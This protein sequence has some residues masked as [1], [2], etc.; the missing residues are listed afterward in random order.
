MRYRCFRYCFRARRR[1]R[2]TPSSPL[3]GRRFISG[4]D[5]MMMRVMA[6]AIAWATSH[7]AARRA[8]HARPPYGGR[9][10]TTGSARHIFLILLMLDVSRH[11]SPRHRSAYTFD[12]AMPCHSLPAVVQ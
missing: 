5:A 3:A 10:A 2:A 8:C 4:D 9:A 6:E 1:V 12:D 11:F 7:I